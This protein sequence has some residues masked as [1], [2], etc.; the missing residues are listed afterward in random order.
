MPRTIQTR[1]HTITLPIDDGGVAQVTV[2]DSGGGHPFLLL[3]GG[4]GPQTVTGFGDLLASTTHARVIIPTH[5]GFGGTI[6][7]AGLASVRGLAVLYTALLEEMDLTD[8]TVV[9][10]SMGGWIAAEMALLDSPRV[11]SVILV[12]AAGIEV[13]GHPVADVFSLTPDQVTRLSFHDPAKFRIDPAKLPPAAQAA[14]PG[15]RASLAVYA[16]KTS[17][18]PSLLGRLPGITMPVLVLWGEADLIVDP[19]YGRAFAAAIPGAQ[20]RL[21][22]E[23]GHLPQVETPQQALEAIWDFAHANVRRHA[24]HDRRRPSGGPA[25]SRTPMWSTEYAVKTDVGAEAIWTALRAWY[26]GA[27]PARAATG[28]SC[29]ARSPWA[30]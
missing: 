28:S 30:A 23:T 11:T 6:R 29:M 9:G 24:P 1:T 12:D 16:G 2:T 26:T 4:G 21:L 10:N 18:D 22:A 15:N 8:V 17:T 25:F 13:S 5:P 27:A 20:F 19:D 7:P 3:H 14:L